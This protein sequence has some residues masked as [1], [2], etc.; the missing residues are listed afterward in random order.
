MKQMHLINIRVIKHVIFLIIEPLSTIFNQ[1]LSTGTVP[2]NMKVARITPIHKKG[3]ID[4]INNY[5]PVSVLNIFSKI[6][7]RCIYERLL[8]F[9]NKNDI[10]LKTSLD[11]GRDTPHLQQS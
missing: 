6:L 9:V 1:S 3:R 7:E 10:Y 4:D 2:N 11:S 8:N 5:R